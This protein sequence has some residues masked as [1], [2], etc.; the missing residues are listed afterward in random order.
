M[1]AGG[2]GFIDEGELEKYAAEVAR[3][4]RRFEAFR[5]AG[6]LYLIDEPIGPEVMLAVPYR[7]IA[8]DLWLERIG[9]AIATCAALTYAEDPWWDRPGWRLKRD[10]ALLYDG[11]PP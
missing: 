3:R 5:V 10:L 6:R 1:S 9:N 2:M 11:I 4:R 7:M 8:H